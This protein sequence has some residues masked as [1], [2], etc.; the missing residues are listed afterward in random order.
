MLRTIHL[1]SPFGY[2]NEAKK[3]NRYNGFS[4]LYAA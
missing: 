4:S 3:R 1:I 2:L